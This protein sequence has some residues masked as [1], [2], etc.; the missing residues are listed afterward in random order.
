MYISN[1]LSQVEHAPYF[2]TRSLGVIEKVSELGIRL[3]FKSLS[4]VIHDRYGCAL[5]LA[6]EVPILLCRSVGTKALVDC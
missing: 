3:S 1:I 5:N 4:D 2:T 6:A